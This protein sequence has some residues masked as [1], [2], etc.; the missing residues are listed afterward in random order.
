M[1]RNGRLYRFNVMQGLSDIGL[2]EHKAIGRIATY[3]DRYLDDPD[4]FDMVQTCVSNLCS[5]GQRMGYATTE[6]W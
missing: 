2:E 4:V 1:V 5:G 3:T 6:G